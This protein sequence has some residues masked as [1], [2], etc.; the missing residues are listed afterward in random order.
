MEFL[1]FATGQPAFLLGFIP[2]KNE[3]NFEFTANAQPN[4]ATALLYKGRVTYKK[5]VAWIVPVQVT[6]TDR[7]YNSNPAT[8]PSIII[9]EARLMMA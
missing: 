2:G 1:A 7:S 6:I 3:V 4:Q 9:R 5:S 8:L